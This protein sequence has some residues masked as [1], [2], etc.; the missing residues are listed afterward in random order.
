MRGIPLGPSGYRERA[1]VG[2]NDELDEASP[3][4]GVGVAAASWSGRVGAAAASWRGRVGAAAGGSRRVC[5][6]PG[7]VGVFVTERTG[8]GMDWIRLLKAQEQN[9]KEKRSPE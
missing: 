1:A 8:D 3:I 9:G 4:S 2:M 6:S 5:V 7:G